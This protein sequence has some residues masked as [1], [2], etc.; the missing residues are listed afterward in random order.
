MI[1]L[2]FGDQH[3]DATVSYEVLELQQNATL[4]GEL[5]RR[6]GIRANNGERGTYPV[7]K[8]GAIMS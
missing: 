8:V 5:R 6:A 4:S 7:E 3:G 2:H 1:H